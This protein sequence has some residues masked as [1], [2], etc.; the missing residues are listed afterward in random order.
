MGNE[1]WVHNRA[2]PKPAARPSRRNVHLPNLMSF[3]VVARHLNFA[4]AAE[5]LE[6]TPTA[7]SKTIKQL[8]AQLGARLFNRT[9][10]SVALTESGAQLLASLS[11]A[12]AQIRSSVESARSSTDRPSGRLRINTSFIAHV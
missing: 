9:T 6:I 1:P 4:R 11:P 12:L 10:R 2:M 7:M 3:E 5:E 8:E